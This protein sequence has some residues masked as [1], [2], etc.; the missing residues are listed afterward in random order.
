M[1]IPAVVGGTV[2]EIYNDK[3]RGNGVRIKGEDGREYRYVHMKYAPRVKVGTKVSAGMSLGQIGS[4]GDSTGPHLDLKVL[5]SKGN[6]LNPM[7]VLKSIQSASTSTAVKGVSNVPGAK[8]NPSISGGDY[9]SFGIN[10][11]KIDKEAK[12]SSS[13]QTYKS[14]LSQAISSGVI[15]NDPKTI[16]A[17]TEL[18][19]RESTWNPKADNQSSTAWGYGQFL[20]DTRSNYKA[21]YPK[22]DY[23]NPVDQIILTYLYTK[24]RYGGPV[25]AIQHHDKENWY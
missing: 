2:I 9:K 24:D 23:N 6:Y 22:Y 15:P 16:V 20:N 8:N 3:D 21:K 13:Y 19:G 1:A 7:Q 10:T 11:K 4:T 18:I 25:G 14:H 5:D 17:L 12:N